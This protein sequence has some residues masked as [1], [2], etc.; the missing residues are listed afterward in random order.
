MCRTRI[1]VDILINNAGLGLFGPVADFSTHDLDLVIQT[2]LRGTFLCCR[3]AM[4]LMIRRKAGYIINISSV[5]G[6]KGY[7]N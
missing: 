4:K 1:A 5:V 7:P 3:E 2:N 6:F